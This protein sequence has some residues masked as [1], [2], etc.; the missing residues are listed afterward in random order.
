MFSV[1]ILVCKLSNPEC[2]ALTEAQVF[3]KTKEDCERYASNLIYSQQQRVL[4][5]ELQPFTADFQYVT[6]SKA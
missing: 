6:W 4:T 5:G 1:I 2:F 3:F